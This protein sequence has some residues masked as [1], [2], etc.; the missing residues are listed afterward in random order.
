M[1]SKIHLQKAKLDDWRRIVDFPFWQTSA[2]QWR[3]R[4]TA[5]CRT[6]LPA[7]AGMPRRMDEAGDID[8]VGRAGGTDRPHQHT[9]PLGVLDRAGGSRSHQRAAG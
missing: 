4:M 9:Q 3:E 6:V 7:A 2:S 1:R 5:F 8:G